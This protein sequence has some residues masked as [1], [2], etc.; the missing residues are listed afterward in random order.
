MKRT[1]AFLLALLTLAALTACSGS[2]PGQKANSWRSMLDVAANLTRD[3]SREAMDKVIPASA[4]DYMI[5]EYQKRGRDYMASIEEEYGEL[6]SQYSEAYGDDYRIEY[7]VV[8]T[9]EKDKEGIE[10]YKSFDSHYFDIYSIDT[11]AIQAVTFVTVKI[12]ISGSKGSYEREKTLQCF[13]VG[14][15]W[16]SF[17]G[18]MFPTKLIA[19]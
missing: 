16:Y 10:S 7:T 6:H 17:Y 2:N 13:C 19:Q 14:G 9:V 3:H 18:L 15:S 12:S 1:F 5:G 4:T 8:K 11:D